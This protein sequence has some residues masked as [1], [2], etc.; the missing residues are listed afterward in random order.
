MHYSMV[1]SLLKLEKC[2]EIFTFVRAP[3]DRLLSEYRWRVKFFNETRGLSDWIKFAIKS[4]KTNPFSFDNHLR[5]QYEFVGEGV[6]VLRLEDGFATG[7]KTVL[8]NYDF[9][10]SKLT[11]EMRANDR[12]QNAKLNNDERL[13]VQDWYERDYHQ[14]GYETL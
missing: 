14:F 7:L 5:P 6:T 9:D 13:I 11:V 3:H 2:D 4:Y 8:S 1:D 12:A 10:F